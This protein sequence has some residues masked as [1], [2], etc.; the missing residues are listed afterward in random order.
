VE[1]SQWIQE[2][3]PSFAARGVKLEVEETW[4]I[5]PLEIHEESSGL[6]RRTLGNLAANSIEAGASSLKISGKVILEHFFVTLEDNGSGV[7][8]EI[9][10]SL[11]KRPVTAGKE[12]GN[13]LGVFSAFEAV[14]GLG[15]MIDFSRIEPRGTRVI[16]ALPIRKTLL[17]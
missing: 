2:S 13:G 5:P 3:Q 14:E 7:P 15:G 4:A 17:E 1:I 8:P 6:I 10:D 12:E 9:L 11:G 16:L